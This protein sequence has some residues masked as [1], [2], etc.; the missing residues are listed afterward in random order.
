MKYTQGQ[1]VSSIREQAATFSPPTSCLQRVSRED[2]ALNKSTGLSRTDWWD[3]C[4]HTLLLA[5]V[6]HHQSCHMFI[7]T[8]GKSQFTELN[9]Q[10][11]TCETKQRFV[12]WFMISTVH[13]IKSVSVTLILLYLNIKQVPQSQKLT[14]IPN[15]VNF[16]PKQFLTD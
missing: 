11:F 12:A 5:P 7:N 3:C 8:Q 4:G 9:D 15:V 16:I 1:S 10:V 13:C 14:F 6:S 2:Q